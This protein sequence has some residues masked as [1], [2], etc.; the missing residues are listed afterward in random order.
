MNVRIFG[1]LVCSVA[2]AACSTEA[3]PDVSK[4]AAGA[5]HYIEAHCKNGDRIRSLWRQVDANITS[6]NTAGTTKAQLLL[7]QQLLTCS[8]DTSDPWIAQV[9][10]L[11]VSGD[12]RSDDHQCQHQGQGRAYYSCKAASAARR[13]GEEKKVVDSTSFPDVRTYG[14]QIESLTETEAKDDAAG[15]KPR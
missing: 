14:T 7:D 11:M 4:D 13:L 8:A 2:L 12:F 6:G 1:T 15:V 5:V 3:H 10:K 9:T